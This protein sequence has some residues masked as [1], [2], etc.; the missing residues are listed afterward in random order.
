[1]F[2]HLGSAFNVYNNGTIMHSINNGAVSFSTNTTQFTVQNNSGNINL[3]PATGDIYIRV[4]SEQTT[5][6]ASIHSFPVFATDP[7]NAGGGFVK[8]I[9]ASALLPKFQVNG[10]T[11]LG[12]TTQRALPFGSTT[13]EST[14][15]TYTTTYMIPTKC[16]LLRVHTMCQSNAGN[17]TLKAYTIPATTSDRDWETCR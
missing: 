17:L 7:D 9:T 2:T 13:G 5:T 10:G 11:F 15:F 8:Y 14:L 4:N 6:T 16:T 1:M 12:Q 3:L